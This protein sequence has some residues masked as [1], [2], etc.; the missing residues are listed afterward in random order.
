MLHNVGSSLSLLSFDDHF[1]SAVASGMPEFVSAM[2]GGGLLGVCGAGLINNMSH[3]PGARA[4]MLREGAVPALVSLLYGKDGAPTPAVK[5]VG[6]EEATVAAFSALG[7]LSFYD[8][9]RAAILATDAPL[10]L[11]GTLLGASMAGL[12]NDGQM[13]FTYA[14]PLI[15]LNALHNLVEHSILPV[16]R[17]HGRS[18]ACGAALA[19]R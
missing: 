5:A 12:V 2:R 18:L 13:R 4:A 6:G 3:H 17:R 14:S 9:S 11:R 1:I 16:A 15:S 7:G 19:W 10:R 8:D